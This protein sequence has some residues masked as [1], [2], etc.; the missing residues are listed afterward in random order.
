MVII[1]KES[2]FSD[3]LITSCC[4]RY[5]VLQF[6]GK[7]KKHQIQYFRDAGG[8]RDIPDQFSQDTEQE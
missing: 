3:F 5:L 1:F 2:S 7:S 4:P 8:G 6:C